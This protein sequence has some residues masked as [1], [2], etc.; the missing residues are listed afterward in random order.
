MVCRMSEV[1]M[2]RCDTHFWF[3]LPVS[4]RLFLLHG[5]FAFR[6]TLFFIEKPVSLQFSAHIARVLSAIHVFLRKSLCR[7]WEQVRIALVLFAIQVFS[8]KKVCRGRGVKIGV[9]GEGEWKKEKGDQ[10]SERERERERERGRGRGRGRE[11]ERGKGRKG[12][13]WESG[14]E[15]E[16]EGKRERG[17]EGKRMWSA[18]T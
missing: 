8:S 16:K 14:K 7:C 2:Y 13:E 4:L 11:S 10:E 18:I 6:D 15:R 12:G 3:V 1:F 17:K 5:A 9:T